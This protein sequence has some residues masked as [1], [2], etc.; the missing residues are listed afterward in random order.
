MPRRAGVKIKKTDSAYHAFASAVLIRIARLCLNNSTRNIYWR[1]GSHNMEERL[2]SQPVTRGLRKVRPY[3][4]PHATRAKGRW[5]GREILE[6]VSTEFR[7]RSLEYYV[8]PFPTGI[9]SVSMLMRLLGRNLLSLRARR[10]S[11]ASL[12]NR[13]TL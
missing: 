11:T 5:W 13:A 8:R 7:D 12:P 10:R 4:Y 9:Q 1:T 2:M 6:I 3:W